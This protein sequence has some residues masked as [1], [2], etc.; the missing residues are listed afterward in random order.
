MKSY[1]TY[2]LVFDGRAAN[3]MRDLQP[4]NNVRV[5]RYHRLAL[6]IYHKEPIHHASYFQVFVGVSDRITIN[7]TC[8]TISD[9][10]DVEKMMGTMRDFSFAAPLLACMGSCIR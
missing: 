3:L 6:E 9:P 1:K 5:L 7:P 2:G 4:R 10:S 8:Q